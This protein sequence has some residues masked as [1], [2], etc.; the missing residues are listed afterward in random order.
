L[1]VAL[2]AAQ[3]CGSDDG[4][5]KVSFDGDAG[6]GGQGGSPEMNSAA[7]EP[8][9]AAGAPEG[10]TGGTV[11]VTAGMGGTEEVTG[12]AAGAPVV[13]PPEPEL[14]FSVKPGAVGLKGTAL[15]NEP[16]VQNVIYTS[17][18][19]SQDFV[20]GTNAVKVTGVSLGL[21]PTDQIVAFAL[22]QPEPANPLYLFS[23]ADGSEGA[24]PSRTYE[25][26]WNNGGD[27]Q[28]NLYYSDGVQSR[29]GG[30]EGGDQIGYNAL[31]ASEVSIGLSRGVVEGNPPD[32]LTGL[33]AHDARQ[34]ITELFFT[35]A[36][37]DVAATAAPASAI[38]GA[39]ADELGCTV[40]KSALD[41][42]NS[43]AFS[44]ADL[45][46]VPND[47]IDG[48]ALFGDATPSKV[49]FSVSR[50]SQGAVGTALANAV[51]AENRVGATLFESPGDG[52]NTVLK[53]DRDLGLG[54]Y[55]DDEI[56]ALTVIDAPQPSAAHAASCEMTYDPV[57]DGGLVAVYGALHL[58]SKVMVL[59][60]P[61]ATQTSR[62]IA[63]STTT[64]ALLE[65]ADLP[66]GFEDP[67]T[68]AI[69]PL[70]GWSTTKPL[71]KVEYLR[72]TEDDL[73]TGLAVRRYDATGTFAKAFPITDSYYGTYVTALV[74]EPVADRL[75]MVTSNGSADRVYV[76]P[77][78]IASD[79]SLAA[80]YFDLTLPCADE[81]GIPGTD[82]AGN[83]YL[84]KS[85]PSGTEYRVCG[86]TPKGELLPQPYFW[87]V[88][89]GGDDRGFIVPGAAHFL[90]HS[91][92]QP[93][94]I[95]RGVFQTP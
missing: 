7:G 40:F 22:V 93:I 62:A 18:T 60:G 28:S 43:V 4:K 8:V 71:D 20:D 79:T 46:L 31:L 91:G 76:M 85:Q 61:T 57:V 70:V 33:A 25:S 69:A 17:S 72:I 39:A 83:L 3:A 6:M 90:L 41:G 34:P 58:G 51:L 14:L 2:L 55:V 37:A 86:F 78:P 24:Q 53:S 16:N 95:E 9:A 68:M 12:G 67:R 81:A 54:E 26:Y 23:I 74:H 50:G 63:Y 88:D 77:R 75:Y 27:E 64:C 92:T 30:G 45:G 47:V 29:R 44:C 84:A 38:S 1:A 42:N 59:F 52:S 89:A 94:S 80:T 49:I 82:A 87:S 13:L 66:A 32:D 21:D 36:P 35:V 5:K 65:Q 48:L 73:A 10:G 15:H 56:D 19:G 11:A